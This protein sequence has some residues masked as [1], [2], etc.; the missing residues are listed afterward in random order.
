MSSRD[1]LKLK[2]INTQQRAWRSSGPPLAFLC[3]LCNQIHRGGDLHEAFIRRGRSVPESITMSEW[4]CVILCHHCHMMYG[5]TDQTKRQLLA[6][7]LS[8]GIDVWQIINK[9]LQVK[10]LTVNPGLPPKENIIEEF[11]E[12]YD[13]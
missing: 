2:I 11:K 9:L 12:R 4:N 3:L 7:K 8:L 10:R 13:I 6:F 5:Q 1:V